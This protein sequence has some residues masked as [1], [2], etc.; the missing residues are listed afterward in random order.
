MSQIEMEGGL[1]EEIYSG[2]ALSNNGAFIPHLAAR[3]LVERSGQLE[4]EAK[5][6][7]ILRSPE[8]RTALYPDV[9]PVLSLIVDA[10][11]SLSIWTQGE[12]EETSD[13]CAGYQ[14]L[15]VAH[16]GIFESLGESWTAINTKI[17]APHEIGGFDKCEQL[18][19]FLRDGQLNTESLVFIDDKAEN[20][21]KAL[22]SAKQHGYRARAF[23]I[24]RNSTEGGVEESNS[25]IES[26]YDIPEIKNGDA[27]FI[28][29]D[30][31]MMD[32][33]LIRDNMKDKIIA[34]M[35]SS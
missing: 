24:S 13:G 32:H 30:Y 12:F 15:K 25:V 16:S 26:F 19:A 35:R 4:L 34:M 31:T 3:S 5:V 7:D 29:L 1:F 9:L 8:S 27:Y 11:S 21:K 14:R 33:S 22:Q 6:L 20:V 18:D 2:L 23:V 17:H 28:D 10:Q